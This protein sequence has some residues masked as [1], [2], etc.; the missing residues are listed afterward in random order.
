M[1]VTPPLPPYIRRDEDQPEDRNRYQTLFAESPGA[2]AAPT[3]GLHF[4]EEVLAR[5]AEAGAETAQLT[6]HVGLGTFQ[7]VE[8]EKLEDHVMHGERY[9]LSE[10]VASAWHRAREANGRVVAVGSTSVRTL[11]TVMARNGRMEAF[12]GRS[13]LFIYPPYSFQA[14]DLMLTNFHLPC[15]TLIMMV[16]ALAGMEFTLEAYRV[17]VEEKYRFFDAGCGMRDA[18]CGMRDAGCGMRDA[19]CGMRDAGCGMRDAGCGMRDAGCGMRDACLLFSGALRRR[20]VA[21]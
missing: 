5:I 8:A 7:S 20:W 12:S 6:L 2:V 3:A 11:E 9:E 10:S 16:S 4:T 21:L 14:V 13:E 1:W 18:G 17:A 19:G 15:S